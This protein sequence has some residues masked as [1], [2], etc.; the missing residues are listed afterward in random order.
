MSDCRDKICIVGAGPSGLAAAKTFKQHELSFDVIDSGRQVGGIWDASNPASPMYRSAHLISSRTLTEFRDFPM[1]DD[2]PDYP[3]HVQV[4]RYL[5]S[6]AEHFGLYPHVELEREVIRIERDGDAWRV[7]INDGQVRRYA[8]MVLATGLDWTPCLPAYPGQFEGMVM[9]SAQYRTPDLFEDKRVLIVGAGNSGCDIAVEAAA[10]AQQTYLSLRRGYYFIP[11]YLF[12]QPAD[13]FG[14]LSVKW[15]LPLWLRR[16]IDT[17]T[18]NTVVGRPERFGFPKPDHRLFES[19]PTINSHIL[20]HA[21]EGSIIPKPDV[22]RLH[23]RE[24]VFTDGTSETIDIIVW[25]TGYSPTFPYIDKQYVNWQREH[26]EL[27]LHIFHPTIDNLAVLGLIKPDSGVW[28]ICEQ[29]AELVARF[30]LAC[31][32][33]TPAAERFRRLKAG[34][35]PDLG[36]GI[37]YLNSPRHAFEVEHVSYSRRLGKL[38][39]ALKP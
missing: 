6:Y 21:G 1:P 2:Y 31:R 9:H 34:P 4:L 36:N 13:V 15:R 17:W 24:I 18:L 19:H 33:Y 20:V 25:A 14:E 7:T 27:Y 22:D 39:R 30:F 35:Q 38:I 29:Q 37:R 10:V 12:G 16:G 26:P 11:K 32:Q 5:H 28:W 23:G 8:A 3:S